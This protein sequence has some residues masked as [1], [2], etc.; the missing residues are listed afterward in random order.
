MFKVGDLVVYNPGPNNG[1]NPPSFDLENKSTG[2]IV[3]I[4]AEHLYAVRWFNHPHS[5]IV[6]DDAVYAEI[7]LSL[8]QKAARTNFF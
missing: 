3:E 2:M 7:E 5:E 4:V 1:L 8:V 6:G